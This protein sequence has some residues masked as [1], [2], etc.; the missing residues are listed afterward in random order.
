MSVCP[1]AW[2]NSAPTGRIFMKFDI[3]VFFENLLRKFKF[4]QNMTRIT[5]A[6]HEG[7]CA[8]MIISDWILP[9]MRNISD[10]SCKE[11]QNTCLCLV[12][13]PCKSCRLWD[14][15]EK[16]GTTRQATDDNI[17]RR[18]RFACWITK[19]T[20]TH[21]EYIILTAFSRQLWFRQKSRGHLLGAPHEK[22]PEVD[23]RNWSKCAVRYI[24]DTSVDYPAVQGNQ[25]WHKWCLWARNSTQW[26]RSTHAYSY[27]PV[28]PICS[29]RLPLACLYYIWYY[30]ND[31][32]YIV[33]S[34]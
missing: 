18:M 6:L 25:T 34:W 20:D 12:T 1:S 8:F 30:S 7:L 13:F 24:L 31:N 23:S 32:L 3:Y 5:G 11:N 29:L 26:Q 2:N 21:S 19:A 33:S 16:Y 15:M 9:R 22:L 10:K 17:T 28:P 27:T 4:H 14:N